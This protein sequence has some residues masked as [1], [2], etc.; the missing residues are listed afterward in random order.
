MCKIKVK[1]YCNEIKNYNFPNKWP[2]KLP[3]RPEIG[4]TISSLDSLELGIIELI[5]Y[6]QNDEPYLEIYLKAWE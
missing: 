2:N 4:D 3:Y 6:C 5:I 1:C